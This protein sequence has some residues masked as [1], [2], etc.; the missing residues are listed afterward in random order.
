MART[1]SHYSLDAEIGR[2][3]MGVVYAATDTRLGRRVA[4]KVLPA[5][6]TADPDRRRRFLQEARTASAL[7]HPNIVTI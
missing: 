5:E 7:N 3:G 4:I 1:L 2:G 6:A